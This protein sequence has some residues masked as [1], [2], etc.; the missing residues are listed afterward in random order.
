MDFS[1]VLPCWE[2][3]N[4]IKENDKMKETGDYPAAWVCSAF[5]LCKVSADFCHLNTDYREVRAFLRVA[6]F[7]FLL[8]LAHTVLSLHM[9]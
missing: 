1:S 4:G 8:N 5:F 6:E 3:D 2:K 9:G 7:G